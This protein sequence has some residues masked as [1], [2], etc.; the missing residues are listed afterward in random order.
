MPNQNSKAG[1]KAV[2]TCVVCRGKSALD[3]MLSFV[4]MDGK[5]VFD[6]RG[7]IQSRKFHLCPDSGC[8]EGLPQWLKRYGKKRSATTR[9]GRK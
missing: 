2:R 3:G 6:F 7:A 4:L 1:H 8:V 9:G 5:L